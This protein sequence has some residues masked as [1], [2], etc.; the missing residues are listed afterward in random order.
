MPVPALAKRLD[1]VVAVMAI[2]ALV[3]VIFVGARLGNRGFDPSTFIVMGAESSDAETLAPNVVTI[4]DSEGYD[5]QYYYRIARNPWTSGGYD[6]GVMLRKA[7]YYH[8]RILY[9]LASW[10]VSFGQWR[11]TPWAMIVVNFAGLVAIG[12]IGALLA[13]SL[14]RHAL[15]GLVLSLYP[16]LLLTLSRDLVEITAAVCLLSGALMYRRGMHGRAA[17]AL[18]LA[19]LAKETLLLAALAAFIAISFRH[20]RIEREPRWRYYLAPLVGYYAWQFAL[21]LHWDEF[22][23]RAGGDN[24]GVP[25]L[26][27]LSFFITSA[28]GFFNVSD[29]AGTF[30]DKLYFV[31]ACLVIVFACAVI[32]AM[33]TA[34]ATHF[35]LI[36]WGLYGVLLL[37]L[38]DLVW[39][40]DWAFLRASTEFYL[41][42]AVVLLSSSLRWR[43]WVFAGWGAL[44]CYYFL[45]RIVSI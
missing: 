36:A 20:Q 12:G 17:V 6:N 38:S 23:Y 32:A 9:P 5:G 14:G 29:I 16:G 35:E 28:R 44:W 26:A 40:E 41:L 42:G 10:C 25:G 1:S 4:P 2:T 15:W 34:R 8:Q 39:V 3:Y 27:F 45:A 43:Q 33:R 24:I 30:H 21:F 18:T 37:A 22:P 7:P 31:E 19:I 11:L 13:R